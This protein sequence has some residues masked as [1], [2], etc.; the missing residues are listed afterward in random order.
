MLVR[1]WATQ[2]HSLL[3][4]WIIIQPLGSLTLQVSYKANHG[5]VVVMSN[6]FATPWTTAHQAPLSIEFSRQE[7]WN[8]LVGDLPDPGINPL[9]PALAGGFF[10]TEPLGK[11]CS[12]LLPAYLMRQTS[13]FLLYWP[14]SA[15]GQRG[16][17]HCLGE[18]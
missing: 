8:G 6:S 3:M 18:S 12:G 4:K 16:D 5:L 9:S 13:F 17:C 15:F 7:Y 2:S 1:M 10:T 14:Q 11:L